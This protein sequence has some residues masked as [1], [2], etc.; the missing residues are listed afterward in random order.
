MTC[1]SCSRDMTQGNIYVR[2]IGSSLFWS[3]DRNVRFG[4]RKGLLQLDL[5]KISVTPAGA[6]AV[7]EAWQCPAC[8]VV[9]LRAA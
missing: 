4:S 1:P 8:P 7:V 3:T 9:T 2:G 5:F 6:Q